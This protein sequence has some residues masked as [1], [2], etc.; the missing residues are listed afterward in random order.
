MNIFNFELIESCVVQEPIIVGSDERIHTFT[1]DYDSR[2]RAEIDF[3]V[4][5][6]KVIVLDL[7][8]K[9]L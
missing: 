2:V 8:R 6:G 1:D 4:R 9:I 5:D 7:R 3:L